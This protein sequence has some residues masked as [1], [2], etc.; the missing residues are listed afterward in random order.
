MDKGKHPGL[1]TRM[2]EKWRNEIGLYNPH[3]ARHRQKT[4]FGAKLN[5]GGRLDSLLRLFLGEISAVSLAPAEGGRRH[6][7]RAQRGSEEKSHS[8]RCPLLWEALF[9]LVAVVVGDFLFWTPVHVLKHVVGSLFEIYFFLWGGWTFSDGQLIESLRDFDCKRM[10]VFNGYW[11]FL[12]LQPMTP[13]PPSVS[14]RWTLECRSHWHSVWI[15]AKRIFII[16]FTTKRLSFMKNLTGEKGLNST[17][18]DPFGVHPIG[19]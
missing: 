6:R 1:K 3:G 18:G 17:L 13:C 2:S 12:P 5:R 4:T 10:L 9:F 8:S 15:R 16:I 19:Q 7:A 14:K 11:L